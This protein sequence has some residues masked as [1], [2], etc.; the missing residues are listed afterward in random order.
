MSGNKHA[1]NW[2]S[3]LIA[4]PV[5]SIASLVTLGFREL[6]ETISAMFFGH[7][8]DITQAIRVYPWFFWPLILGSGGLIA[9]FF[10]KYATSIERKSTVKTDYLEIINAR[11]D[12]VPAKT[13]LFRALSSIA[14]ICSG[15]SIGKEGP[16]VQLS[17]LCGSIMGRYA[18]PRLA[19]RNSDVVAMAASAGLASVYHAPLASA[20]FVA[21]IA[22]GVFAL[23]RLIPLIIASAVGVMTMWSL[24][25]HSTLYP[26]VNETFRLTTITFLLTLLIALVAGLVGWLVI[27]LIGQC[28]GVFSRIKNL[29]FRLAIGGV[30]TGLLAIITPDILGNGYDVIVRLMTGERIL[31]F[32][33][34]LLGLKLMATVLSV[35]S[36]AVGGL[37]TPSLLIGALLGVLM[38]SLAATAGLPVDNICLFAVIGMGAV[39]AAV[40]QAPLMAILMMLEM[41][42]NS[43]LLFPVML[44]TSLAS[45][46][47]YQLHSSGTYPVVS[48]HFRRSEAQYDFDNGIIAQFMS[49][50][51]TLQPA[52]SVGRALAVSSLKR[53][54][55]VYI[56]SETQQFLG[57]VS[58]HEISRKI[59]SH[60]LTA[61]SPVASVMDRDFPCVYA[62]QT[63]REGWEAFAQVTLE[64]LPVLNNA[65][66]RR[67]LGAL[68]KTSLIQQARNFI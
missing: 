29:P 20:I 5:G 28:K 39:L 45:L 14:S 64:R 9:G 44:A 46:M 48:R 34:L 63:L 22:F 67:F 56:V 25:F 6:V 17:A 59:L 62:H 16:M 12:A 38:A 13:S 27:F 8:H 57:V 40:S 54:R 53:E 4:I 32:M 50:G 26:F 7:N 36:N 1:L 35:G 11:L 52:V 10:L 43:S 23:Q 41:T 49:E 24:G 42:L 51:E 33:L 30:I 55:F 19:L 61:D 65:T 15:A 31:P 66:E 68:T 58:V 2:T 18:F 60:E 21:E 37:F 47:A 3:I